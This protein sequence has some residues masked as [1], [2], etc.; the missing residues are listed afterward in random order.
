MYTHDIYI[1]I[2]IYICKHA[3]VQTDHTY[4]LIYIYIYT[5]IPYAQTYMHTSKHTYKSTY[6]HTHIH[7][8]V[9]THT[10]MNT[11]IHTYIHTCIHPSIRTCAYI[12]LSEGMYMIHFYEEPLLKSKL[13]Y[14][15]R[16]RRTMQEFLFA[17]DANDTTLTTEVTRHTCCTNISCPPMH[18][19]CSH[20]FS[21]MRAHSLSSKLRLCVDHMFNTCGHDPD[22]KTESD[23]DC[24]HDNCSRVLRNSYGDT[25]RRRELIGIDPAAMEKWLRTPTQSALQTNCYTLMVVML[26]MVATCYSNVVTRTSSAGPR[27]QL[28]LVP[29]SDGVYCRFSRRDIDIINVPDRGFYNHTREGRQHLRLL[30]WC[31]FISRLTFTIPCKRCIPNIQRTVMP[32]NFA[33]HS[34]NRIK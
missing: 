24:H 17:N 8:Y 32:F 7:E 26:G 6:T 9:H 15:M 3:Y 21:D 20:H 27:W 30:L 31:V 22:H 2:Y 18:H 23:R 12:H 14:Y 33:M 28:R 34:R 25:V 19:I 13:A 29:L 10:H 5:C 4:I 1:Y 16:V 11:Y